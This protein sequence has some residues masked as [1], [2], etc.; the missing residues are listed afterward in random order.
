[1]IIYNGTKDGFDGAI[2][3]ADLRAVH[4]VADPEVID[5]VD[6]KSFAPIGSEFDG[7]PTLG[8]D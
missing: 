5:I 2:E 6:L 8:F 4:E 3:I 1:M 7:E